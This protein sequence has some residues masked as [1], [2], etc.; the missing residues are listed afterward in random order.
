MSDHYFSAEPASASRPRSFELTV[1]GVS[2][3]FNSDS[4]VFSADK[5]DKGSRVLLEALLRFSDWTDKRVLDLGCGYGAIGVTLAK[6]GASAVM[7]DVNERALALC[8]ENAALNG[9]SAECLSSDAGEGV[10]GGFDAVVTNP[11]IRAGKKT[12][13]AFFDN[14]HKLLKSGGGLFVVIRKQQGAESAE[15]HIRELFGNCET[16]E[17][18]AG[19]RVLYSVKG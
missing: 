13:Y 9:V 4:G 7:C 6:A 18:E 10:E 16:I 8:R 12:V 5:V 2:V 15:K 1:G 11:P 19:Y 3:R 14:A 17:K